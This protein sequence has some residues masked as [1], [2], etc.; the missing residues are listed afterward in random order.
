MSLSSIAHKWATHKIDEGDVAP[1]SHEPD[2]ARGMSPNDMRDLVREIRAHNSRVNCITDPQD[3]EESCGF[4]C[5]V[6]GEYGQGCGA[7]EEGEACDHCAETKCDHCDGYT[8]EHAD[9]DHACGCHLYCRE[10]GALTDA[11]RCE[12]ANCGRCA[13]NDPD[14]ADDTFGD[15]CKAARTGEGEDCM[16][17]QMW[18]QQDVWKRRVTCP[19]Y[20]E[21]DPGADVIDDSPIHGRSVADY[22]ED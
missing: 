4:P 2:N 11:C 21:A 9:E 18:L 17:A 19:V 14:G 8:T 13:N 6:C 10:C 22:L 7:D 5:V 20:V 12:S 15:H 3:Y 16:V 1:Y